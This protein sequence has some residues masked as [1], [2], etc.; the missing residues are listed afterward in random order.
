MIVWK[1]ATRPTTAISASSAAAVPSPKMSMNP[2]NSGS[3]VAPMP[4]APELVPVLRNSVPTPR[5]T[6]VHRPHIVAL[7]MSRLGSIDSSAAS[8]SSSIAR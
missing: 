2:W 3:A 6:S 4:A 5:N 8:G 1:L 7:G